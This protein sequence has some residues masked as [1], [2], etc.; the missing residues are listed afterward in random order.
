MDI[1][2]DLS[3]WCGQFFIIKFQ[4]LAAGSR[5]LAKPDHGT[6]FNVIFWRFLQT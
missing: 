2:S 3:T 5:P 1:G 6:T 4:Y